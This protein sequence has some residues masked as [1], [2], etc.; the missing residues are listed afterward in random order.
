MAIKKLTLFSAAA[1][2]SS[3]AF[4]AVADDGPIKIG[5]TIPLSPPGAVEMGVEARTGLEIMRDYVNENGGV[6]GRMIELVFEDDQGIPERGRAATEKLITQDNV[7]AVTGPLQ[8]SV[9]LA[10][11]E[12]AHRYGTPYV[13]TNC[14]SDAVR[15]QGYPEVFSVGNYNSRVSSAVAQTIQAMGVKRV[16][17][18]AE[19]TDYGIG[20][21]NLIADILKDDDSVDF[22]FEILDRAGKDFMPAVLPLRSNPP[23]MTV[24][25]MLPPASYVIGNQLYEQG[26]APSS[27][28]WMY[29]TGNADFPDF[30]QNAGDSGTFLMSFGLYHP[31]MQMPELGQHVSEE[32]VKR[33]NKEPNRLTFQAADSVW[34]IA[35]AIRIGGSDD[36]E[37]M[38]S[39][40]QT[41]TFDSVR[42]S[43]QFSQ[44]PGPYFQSWKDIPY[45]N[46]QFTE[47]NQPMSQSTLLEGPGL[48]FSMDR[49]TPVQ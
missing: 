6:D 48:P 41:M 44:E 14:W 5:V 9:C 36:P 29:D 4:F 27:T 26:I 37:T 24:N 38:I 3:V 47:K 23:D 33:M 18:F 21:A 30:W 49:L 7:V 25:L 46:I 16:V 2:L 20:L 8:S 31:Q 35:E 1:T 15:E 45:V 10:S 13:N 42:G 34:L 19:N 22:K 43:F 11:I 28:T 39:T 17:A 32:Y 12:V 40:M